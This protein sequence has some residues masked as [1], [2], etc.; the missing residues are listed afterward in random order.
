MTYPSVVPGAK[1]QRPKGAFSQV[2]TPSS[3][4][5]SC[6]TRTHAGVLTR[7]SSGSKVNVSPRLSR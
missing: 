3:D 4:L 1:E 6:E 2:L 7:E 5:V